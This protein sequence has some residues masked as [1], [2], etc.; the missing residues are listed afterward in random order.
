MNRKP[1]VTISHA[2]GT[3]SVY[4]NDLIARGWE[5]VPQ[6]T[7]S[8]ILDT[9]PRPHGVRTPFFP[10]AAR[11]ASAWLREKVRTV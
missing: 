1:H 8:G 2:P 5:R 6:R 3:R 7:Y 10:L 11:V 9:W 4:S